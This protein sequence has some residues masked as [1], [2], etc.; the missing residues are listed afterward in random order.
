MATRVMNPAYRPMTVEEF[1]AADLGDAKAELVDGMI[2]MMAGGSPRH[3]AIAA[4]LITALNTRLRGSGCEAYGSD[5]AIRTG[6]ASVR[7][8]DVSVYCQATPSGPDDQLLGDPKIVVEVLSPSTASNDQII[9]LAE[10]RALPGVEAIV[11]I[12]PSSDRFRVIVP[13]VDSRDD[14]LPA[15]SPLDLPMLGV[16]IPAE[17]IFLPG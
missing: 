1:L 2:F 8:P 16:T 6:P 14:W 3:A 5:L 17:G 13:R 9:K 11:F 10:Y 4:R 15:N 12:D 7:F